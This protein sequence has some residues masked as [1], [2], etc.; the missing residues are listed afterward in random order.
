MQ[1]SLLHIFYYK[2]RHPGPH[3]QKLVNFAQLDAFS[4]R[5]EASLGAEIL[6]SCRKGV[7]YKTWKI[8]QNIII[9][10]I[11]YTSI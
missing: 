2:T 6:R 9:L 3:N 10:F 7:E 1:K 11:N 5:L 4:E 8:L